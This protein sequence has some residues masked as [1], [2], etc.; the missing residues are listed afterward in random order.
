[1]GSVPAALAWMALWAV[2][3]PSAT[4][5]VQLAVP[6]SVPARSQAVVVRLDTGACIGTWPLDER[7]AFEARLPPGVYLVG[8]P[9]AP[10][11]PARVV[12]LQADQAASVVVG[13]PGAKAVPTPPFL[14]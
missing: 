6:A 13:C 11:R 8:L 12:S 5:R 1:M 7:G 2:P 9:G 14:G 4:L 10:G 3:S